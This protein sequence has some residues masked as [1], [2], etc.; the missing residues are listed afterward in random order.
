MVRIK[1]IDIARA[2]CII[3][4]VIGHYFPDGSPQWYCNFRG[5]IYSFHMPAFMFISGYVYQLT[6]KEQPYLKFA[7]KKARR[8]LVPYLIVSVV[9]ILIKIL[10]QSLTGVQV[11][12]PVGPDAFYKMFIGPEAAFHLWFILALWWLFLVAPLFKSKASHIVL[13]ALGV[14]LHYLPSL[15]PSVSYPTVFCLNYSAEYLVFFALGI[16]ARDSGISFDGHSVWPALV[17]SA[18]FLVNS[19]TGLCHLVDPYIGIA[20]IMG[21]SS[22]AGRLPD[23]SLS[24]LLTVSGASYTIYLVHSLFLGF[25]ITGLKVVPALLDT[26]GPYFLVGVVVIT[27]TC[28]ICCIV[29][30]LIL[31][32]LKKSMAVPIDSA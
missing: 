10:S 15:V 14:I 20:G 1:S 26:Q 11:K 17:L 16:V 8:L 23:K 21:L 2:I 19:V 18:V 22:L 12:N 7:G 30:H 13:L 3:L 29:T 6:H 31:Q 28:V 4:V 27:V 9:I 25:I 32:R 5:W 24:P